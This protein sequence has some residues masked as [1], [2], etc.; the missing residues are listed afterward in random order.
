MP[1]N[2]QKI[3]SDAGK[4]QLS[5]VPLKILVAIARIR[6]YGLKKYLTRDGWKRV[7][8]QRYIDALFRHLVA[9]VENPYGLDEES[10]LPHLWH[11]DCN[12]AFLTELT[13]DRLQKAVDEE[14]QRREKEN[15][16][17]EQ[18]EKILSKYSTK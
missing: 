17:W 7:E 2:D 14:R 15:D 16:L 10:G 8:E 1:Q 6:E 4:P 18:K 12:A 13:F 11:L 9:F 5:L 3:K